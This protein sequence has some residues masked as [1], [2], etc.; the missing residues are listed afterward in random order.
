MMNNKNV[1]VT[2]IYLILNGFNAVIKINVEDQ[3]GITFNVLALIAK[4][5]KISKISILHV[6]F[7][8]DRSL[9]NK[10]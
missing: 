7:V 4:I 5:L 1:F 8:K 9:M 3:I 6:N 2:K 10:A